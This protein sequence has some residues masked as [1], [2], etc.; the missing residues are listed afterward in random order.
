MRQQPWQKGNEV[1][2]A[3]TYAYARSTQLSSGARH[4]SRIALLTL[5]GCTASAATPATTHPAPP[6]LPLAAFG[7]HDLVG[8]WRWVFHAD[9][10]GTS[11]VE[12]EHWRFQAIPGDVNH[13]AGRYVR[14]V[15]VRSTDRAPFQCNQRPAY[16]QRA[17]FDVE[18]T[19]RGD[20]YAIH[21]LG[22]RAESSPCDH[23][24]RHVGDYTAELLGN[25]L[26]LR[27][28][29]GDQTLWQTDD[30]AAELPDPPWPAELSPYGPWRWEATSYDESGYLRDETEWW[31]LTRRTDTIVD[32][33]YRRRVTVRSGDGKPIACANGPS[34]SFDDAYVL[35][36]QREEEHWKFVE[37]A[38]SPGDH[39]CLKATPRRML[40]EATAEQIGDYFVFEWRGKRR[41]ILYRPE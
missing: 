31:E 18:A 29:G 7:L 34:Y 16:R 27:W 13:L 39:P 32:A 24:F 21:E 35:S 40:D 41:E 28:P 36:G 6:P 1:A 33:T 30:K 9:D 20:G 3:Y 14:E 37:L 4:V 2:Y 8:G 23:G 12:E 19:V 38:V 22:Y 17:V 5:A 10:K 15:D 25:R 26:A 11:R